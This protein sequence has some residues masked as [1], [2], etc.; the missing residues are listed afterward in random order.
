MFDHFLE[1][2]YAIDVTLQQAESPAG[3]YSKKKDYHSKKHGLYGHKVEV[4]V[5]PVGY[6]IGMMKYAKGSVSDMKIFDDN[7]AFHQSQL[8]KLADER[9]LPVR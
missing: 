6:A 9:N 7:E 1:D 4:T 2:R 3:A 8:V 5:V